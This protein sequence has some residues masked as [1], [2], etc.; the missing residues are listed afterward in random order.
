MHT[1]R[2][3]HTLSVNGLI[4]ETY[5][6]LF[7]TT[8]SWKDRAHFYR[9]FSRSMRHTLIDYARQQRA[10]K[11]SGKKIR[12][13]LGETIQISNTPGEPIWELQHAVEQL[14]KLNPRLAEMIELRFYKQMSIKEIAAHFEVSTRT[15][16]RDLKRAKLLLFRTLIVDHLPSNTLIPS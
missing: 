4:H 5:L 1:Q 11:R 3:D 12:L 6:R 10:T 2:P 8:A 13:S 14:N 16:D 15:V 7:S 9:A